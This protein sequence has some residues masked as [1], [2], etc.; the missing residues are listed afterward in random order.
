MIIYMKRIKK[1]HPEKNGGGDWPSSRE[2]AII[3]ENDRSAAAD[4]V[5]FF[6]IRH[7]V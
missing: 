1:Y 4:N 3:K 6:R 7:I 5:H 2:Y